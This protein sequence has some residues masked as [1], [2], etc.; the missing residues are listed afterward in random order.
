MTLIHFPSS[1]SPRLTWRDIQH[2]I[3]RS[4]QPLDPPLVGRYA[5][6]WRPRPTWRINGANVSGICQFPLKLF[7]RPASSIYSARSLSFILWIGHF[8]YLWGTNLI[9]T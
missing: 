1:F 2:L 7:L 5:L 6:R 3:V 4:S 8:S 9:R